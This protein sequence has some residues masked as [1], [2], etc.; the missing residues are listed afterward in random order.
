LTIRLVLADCAC[1]YTCGP[2]SITFNDRET[3]ALKFMELRSAVLKATRDYH[4]GGR[5][6]GGPIPELHQLYFAVHF[7]GRHIV[8]VKR[9]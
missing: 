6:P 8:A 7:R 3:A 4:R 5:Q 1:G 2:V 9:G